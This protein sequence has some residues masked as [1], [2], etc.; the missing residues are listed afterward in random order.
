MKNYFALLV[1]VLFLVTLFTG[2]ARLKELD[3][4]APPGRVVA[5]SLFKSNSEHLVKESIQDTFMDIFFKK[6]N[7]KPVK[8]KN[9]DIVIE[10]I[11]TIEEGHSR[12]TKGAI[13]GRS[14]GI[15][16]GVSGTS[17]SGIYVSGITVQA[18][19]NGELIATHSVGQDLGRGVLLSPIHLAK[20]AA[21]YI[22][23]IL[24]RQNEIGR[25]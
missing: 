1:A 22:S 12:R 4:T 23:T 24:V 3:N 13:I 20:R 11:I 14:S 8:G 17:A 7:A 9:G 15:G 18:Y 10:G 16:G 25:P 5:I 21:T 19:K 6:T 2:C